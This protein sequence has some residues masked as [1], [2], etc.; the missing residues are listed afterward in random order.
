MKNLHI[1]LFIVFLL[2]QLPIYSQDTTLVK[3]TNNIELPQI[4]TLKPIVF[5]K[6]GTVYYG[7]N[8]EQTEYLYNSLKQRDFYF[9]KYKV[10]VE[11][12]NNIVCEYDNLIDN[13][14]EIIELKDSIITAQVSTIN[15]K[16]KE[17]IETSDEY[18]KEIRKQKIKAAWTTV[19]GIAI[20]IVGGVVATLLLV[21]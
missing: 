20:G 11:D 17:S 5:K 1:M 21:H 14:N 7:F 18:E 19:G 6:Y 13:K 9:H 12:F 2:T 8:T 3:D 15:L 16:D 10:K 4:E